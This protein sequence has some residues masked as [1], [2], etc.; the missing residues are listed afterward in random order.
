M[1][2]ESAC[3]MAPLVPLPIVIGTAGKYLTRSGEVVEITEVS[4]NNDLNCKGVYSTGQPD[5]WHR[6]GRLYS[7]QESA[8]DIVQSV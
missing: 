4:R 6:S 8:N 1:N 7:V 3:F 5:S 2:Y